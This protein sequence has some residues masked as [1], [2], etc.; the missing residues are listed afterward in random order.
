MEHALEWCCRSPAHERC[1][2][3]LRWR[4]PGRA[5]AVC[6]VVLLLMFRATPSLHGG[7]RLEWAPA[8]RGLH[9]DVEADAPPVIELRSD[10]VLPV[11][12]ERSG[13][14]SVTVPVL[15]VRGDGDLLIVDD[16]RVAHALPRDRPLPGATLDPALYGAH[17]GWH[18]QPSARQRQRIAWLGV[19]FALGLMLTLLARRHGPWLACGYA[20]TW[21]GAILILM[22]RQPVLVRREAADGVDGYYARTAQTVR[23]EVG[24]RSRW[25]PIFE[26]IDHLRTLSPRIE[27]RGTR[28][29]VVL[30][31][32]AGAKVLFRSE[33]QAPSW[34]D[35]PGR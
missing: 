5:A 7:T 2:L 26:S 6:L 15:A 14:R 33:D 27:V 16:S 13:L 34:L 30:D 35:E 23:V 12:W 17:S 9:I 25:V 3:A 4:C 10:D 31:L 22:A 18:G 24:S 29:E 11:R 1:P 32:P 8:G 19:L 28:A 21:A 20:V